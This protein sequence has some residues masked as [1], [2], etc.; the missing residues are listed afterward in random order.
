M[1]KRSLLNA[2]LSA[3]TVAQVEA[4]IASF[5]EGKEL[6]LSYIAVGRRPNNRGAIEVATDPGR[7]LIERVTN[8]HDALLEL[9]HELHSGTP[10]CKS[11]REAAGAWLGVP[12]KEGL[13]G[14]SNKQ[15]QDLAINTVVRLEAGE[16]TQSRLVSVI[17]RGIGI[18]P[19][20]LEGTILSLNESNKIQKHYLAGTYGQGGSSTFAFC[21]YVVI[22]SRREGS[23]HIGFTV[24]RYEDLPADEYKTGRYVFLG[25]SDAPLDVLAEEGDPSRGTIVRHFG[26]DLTRYTSPLG[27]RS[28]YGILGR[29][30]FDPVAPVRFENRVHNYNRT[31]KGARNALNGAVDE[32][33]EDGKG[34]TLDHHVPMFSVALGDYGSVGIEYWILALPE[35]KDGK[36]RRTKPA[37]AFVDS[38]KP[39]VLT[40]NGQN[41]GELSG[42]LIR[43]DA[44]LPF[45]QTQGRLICHVNCDRLSANAKRQLFSST[46]EQ[47]REGFML[48]RLRSEIVGALRADDEL[49]RLNEEAREQSLKERDEDA[50]RR[51]RR[52]VAKLLNL[53]GSA[54]DESGGKGKGDGQQGGR[55][56]PRVK[57]LPITPSEPP[58]Y[59]SIRWESEAPI[60]FHAGRRRYIRV[61]TDA[62]SDYHDADDPTKSRINIAVGD[63]LRVFGTSPLKG[64]RMRIGVEC[65]DGVAVG[66]KGSVRVELYRTGL[67]ALSDEKEYVVTEVPE[68]KQKEKKNTLPEFIVIPVSGPEDEQWEFIVDDPD[69]TNVRKHASNAVVNSGKL[70]VY[71]SEVYPRF[72]SELRSFEQQGE[73]VAKS[74]RSRYETWLAVHALILHQQT[75]SQKIEGLGE[76]A[77]A[78]V[79][80]QERSRHATIA[81]M[82]AS[83]E[84]KSGSAADEEDEDA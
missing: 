47:S 61:E 84:V 23:S 80:R 76:E 3:E 51:I 18:E 56:G 46:R 59:V 4:A 69:D 82:M 19:E 79:Y 42:R 22:V 37:D 70:H 68:A 9:E 2:L 58:T 32:G 30:L 40:H 13:A 29:I 52:R 20:R 45:L 71:Y 35:T 66:S 15:R 7:S 38:T 73:A 21:K 28:V 17:D 39:I 25:E 55:R 50:E 24:V 44:D 8:A 5:L 27:P 33:D 62:N 12:E 43:D 54:A 64:G 57:P 74:F 67:P 63:D 48:D 60:R 11:P 1:D 16:G 6:S 26:Y 78:E 81:A 65:L 34:P 49:V 75:D 31:I 77:E 36:R 10:S 14:L 53:V 83:Q 41:Q 72:S